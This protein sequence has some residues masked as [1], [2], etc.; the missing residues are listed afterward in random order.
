MHS[1]VASSYVPGTASTSR[2]SPS[3]SRQRFFALAVAKAGLG[4]K[5]ATL[6]LDAYGHLLPDRLDEASKKMHER[7]SKQ[8]AKAKAKLEKAEKKARKAAEAVAVAVL[9]DPAA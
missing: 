6:T 1:S 8:L 4:H 5:S 2:A 9:E 3:G 7:R